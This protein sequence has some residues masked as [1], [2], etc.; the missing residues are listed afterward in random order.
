[1][2]SH[3]SLGGGG[4]QLLGS[5]GEYLPVTETEVLAAING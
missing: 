4:C 5:L 3:S 2:N 1:M